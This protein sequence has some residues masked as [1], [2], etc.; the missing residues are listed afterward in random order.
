MRIFQKIVRSIALAIALV[1][2]RLILILYNLVL[3]KRLFSILNLLYNKLYNR[4]RP[5][6][7]NMLQ[8]VYIN[9]RVLERVKVDLTTKGKL[10]KLKDALLTISEDYTRNLALNNKIE[11][12]ELIDII[13]D[14]D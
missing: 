9:K 7:V 2:I 12:V 6:R 1:V 4:L 10:I 5:N 14:K 3:S 8:Y 11:E 13:K